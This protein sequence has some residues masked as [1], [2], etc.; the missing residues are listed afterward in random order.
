LVVDA[1]PLVFPA[2]RLGSHRS[3]DGVNSFCGSAYDG[4]E[5]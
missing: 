4:D 1:G 3:T 2:L 5:S